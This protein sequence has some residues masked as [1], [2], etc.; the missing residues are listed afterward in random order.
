M[1]TEG[2]LDTAEG[3]DELIQLGF[4]TILDADDRGRARLRKGTA[5]LGRPDP[6]ACRASRS[7]LDPKIRRR[8]P[9]RLLEPTLLS[10]LLVREGAR[11]EAERK[12]AQTMKISCGR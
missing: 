3:D 12:A 5:A 1:F 8:S 11:G 2:P 4:N 9:Q 10:Y 7:R 6:D